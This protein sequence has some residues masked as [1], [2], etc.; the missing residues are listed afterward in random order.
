MEVLST[1][2]PSVVLLVIVWLTELN[3]LFSGCPLL[4]ILPWLDQMVKMVAEVEVL[5][6]FFL[7]PRTVGPHL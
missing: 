7:Q 5:P 6:Y 2:V 1:V 4:L 3:I